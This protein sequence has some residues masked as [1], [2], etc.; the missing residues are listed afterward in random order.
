MLGAIVSFWSDQLLEAQC[1]CNGATGIA[2]IREPALM[3]PYAPYPVA[4]ID[5]VEHVD[6]AVMLTLAE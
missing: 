1:S 5:W 4:S 3:K 6:G 2:V